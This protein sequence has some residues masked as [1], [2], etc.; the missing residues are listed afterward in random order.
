MDGV[1]T[2]RST[3]WIRRVCAPGLTLV[4]AATGAGT[5]LPAAHATLAHQASASAAQA[6]S[7]PNPA[8]A[9]AAQKR[10]RWISITAAA[11]R[12]GPGTRYKIV[13]HYWKGKKVT[14]T[15]TGTGWFKTS[16][17]YVSRSVLTSVT[18]G[19]VTRYVAG[20]KA[21]YR[22]GPGTDYRRVGSYGK[23]HKVTGILSAHGWLWMPNGYF[24]SG[25]VLRTTPPPPPTIR[26]VKSARANVRTGPSTNYRVVGHY[27]QRTQV[28]GTLTSNGWLRMRNGHYI[29]GVVLSAK[30]PPTLTRYVSVSAAKYRTGPGMRYTARGSWVRGTK[31]KGRMSSSGWLR[32]NGSGFHISGQQLRKKPISTSREVSQHVAVRWGDVYTRPSTSSTRIDYAPK[33]G[34]VKGSVSQGWMRIGTHRYIRMAQLT[35][36]RYRYTGGNGKIAP[37]KLCHLPIPG[38][39][40]RFIKCGGARSGMAAMNKAFRARFG[41][42]LEVDECYRTYG[43]QVF[44]RREKGTKAAVPGY[45]NH[46]RA[47][48]C[49]VSGNAKRYGYGTPREQW[50]V[51]NGPRYGWERPDFMDQGGSNPEFWH[52]EYV[53]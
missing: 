42:N 12:K 26:W 30:R 3:S 17:G 22:T 53:G 35:T 34:L 39:A 50:L 40:H 28:G 36:N 14:G 18:P 5:A 49:D 25:Y 11:V 13:S 41:H 51:K 6:A 20:A 38:K 23:G 8:T 21:N 45:S 9:P 27:W 37:N 10:T 15:F 47:I 16:R 19:V 48:A 33:G 4:L 29:S 32:V 24:I 44:Y 2:N 7:H 52:F 31:V 1:R 46:G 43:T